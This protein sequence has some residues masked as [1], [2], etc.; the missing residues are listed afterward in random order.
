MAARG[1]PSVNGAGFEDIAPQAAGYARC[2]VLGP[3]HRRWGGLPSVVGGKLAIGLIATQSQAPAPHPNLL[4]QRNYLRVA[5][6]K[7]PTAAGT[8]KGF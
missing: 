5:R 8:T 2:C 7:E 4:S 6:G 3:R 1:A